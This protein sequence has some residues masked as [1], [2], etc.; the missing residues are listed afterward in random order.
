MTK[1]NENL[2]LVLQLEKTEKRLRIINSMMLVEMKSDRFLEGIANNVPNETLI[3]GITPKEIRVYEF[4]CELCEIESTENTIVYNGSNDENYLITIRYNKKQD[5]YTVEMLPGYTNVEEIL[6][7]GL[8]PIKYVR[9]FK[10]NP[11]TF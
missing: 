3:E 1:T 11:P 9:T 10:W 8:E 6:G 7:C 2:N 5:K 4:D